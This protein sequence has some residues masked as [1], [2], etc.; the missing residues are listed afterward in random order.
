M[1]LTSPQAFS[2]TIMGH[3]LPNIIGWE[4]YAA[5]VGLTPVTN[6]KCSSDW[7]I[8]P[9]TGNLI[10]KAKVCTVTYR[11]ARFAS[12]LLF[13]QGMSP[14]T[15]AANTFLLGTYSTCFKSIEI[16]NATAPQ[17]H[18]NFLMYFAIFKNLAHSLEPGET[19]NYSASHQAPIYVQRS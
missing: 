19:P 10:R 15:Y 5:R 7:A 2:S 18:R 3:W 8:Q 9:L 14:W 4:K 13:H 6:R 11:A 12:N 1:F 16:I 17:P